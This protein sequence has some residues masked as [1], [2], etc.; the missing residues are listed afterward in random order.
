MK[1]VLIILL[2]FAFQ[3]CKS[4]DFGPEGALLGAWKIS[5]YKFESTDKFGRKTKSNDIG[6][7]RL[8]FTFQKKGIFTITAPP[9]S[10]RIL[11]TYSVR[12]S[13]ISLTA[14]FMV[15][16][17]ESTQVSSFAIMGDVLTFTR[18]TDQLNQSQDSNDQYNYALEITQFTKIP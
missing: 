14:T 3:G 16:G 17:D 4:T 2:F 18:N 13:E 7:D 8:V 12:G 11:G 15:G 10:G 9:T 5:N 6:D 1:T